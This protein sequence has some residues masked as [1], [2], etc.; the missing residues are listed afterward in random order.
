MILD[1]VPREI[2]ETLR[3]ISSL[4][5]LEQRVLQETSCAQGSSDVDAASDSTLQGQLPGVVPYEDV[6]STDL[7]LLDGKSHAKDLAV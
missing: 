1:S 4:A 7:N 5:A 2:R 3:C 6:P